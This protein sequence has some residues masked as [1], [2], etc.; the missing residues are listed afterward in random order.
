MDPIYVAWLGY[1]KLSQCASC[2]SSGA[3]TVHSPSR[4]SLMNTHQTGQARSGSAYLS[5]QGPSQSPDEVRLATAW[6][7][8]F[9][10]L[11][12]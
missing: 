11:C 6:A 9:Y 10:I 5:A 4:P 1:S 8:W 12:A 2:R 7:S 3:N